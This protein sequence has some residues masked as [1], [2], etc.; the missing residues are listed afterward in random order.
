MKG[1]PGSGAGQGRGQLRGGGPVWA[2]Q[3]QEGP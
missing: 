1:A 2:G 3:S